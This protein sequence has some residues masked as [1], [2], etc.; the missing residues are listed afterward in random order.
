MKLSTV[1]AEIDRKYW[2]FKNR[3]YRQMAH[4]EVDI[5]YGEMLLLFGSIITRSAA[6]GSHSFIHSYSFIEKKTEMTKRICTSN[7]NTRRI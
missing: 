4:V 1:G 2:Y 6:D 5:K 7:S 3:Y